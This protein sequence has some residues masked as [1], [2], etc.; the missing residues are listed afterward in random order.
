[1]ETLVGHSLT[2][3]IAS[4]RAQKEK[5]EAERLKREADK[6]A[7]EEEEAAAAL[8]KAEADRKRAAEQ[9]AR[10]ERKREA[11][12]AEAARKAAEKQKRA[13]KQLAEE[14][15]RRAEAE[16]QREKVAQDKA[17]AAAKKEAARVQREA[18][19]KEKR[20]KDKREKE[21]KEKAAAERKAAEEHARKERER[22]QAEARAA[23][24]A[25]QAAQAAARAQ[26]QQSPLQP[27]SILQP[28]PSS[29]NRPMG[30]P[31]SPVRG[32]SA[33][34]N[35]NRAMPPTPVGLPPTSSPAGLSRGAPTVPLGVPHTP[36]KQPMPSPGPVGPFRG[37][38]Q[39]HQPP[40][41]GFAPMSPFGARPPS[42]QGMM[43]MSMTPSATSESPTHSRPASTIAGMSASPM[44]FPQQ[45]FGP[46]GLGTH[47]Q[48]MG[49]PPLSQA[50]S[51]PSGSTSIFSS[52]PTA[53][54]MNGA[55]APPGFRRPSNAHVAPIGSSSYGNIGVTAGQPMQRN[56]SGE[57]ARQPSAIGARPIGRPPPRHGTGQTSDEV[58][59]AALRSPTPPLTF[60]SA[61]LLDDD[62]EDALADSE[63][64]GGGNGSNSSPTASS[65]ALGGSYTDSSIWGGSGLWPAAARPQPPPLAVPEPQAP[66][67]TR[68][69]ILRARL[70][71]I[72]Y[73]LTKDHV[74]QSA[75]SL[76]Y[77]DWDMVASLLVQR[78]PDSNT[79]TTEELIKC[80]ELPADHIN[81]GGSFSLKADP[82]RVLIAFQ[83]QD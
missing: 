30:M 21:K 22:Q 76:I 51:L 71:V 13:E 2:A 20:E 4:Y 47:P 72:C 11:K 31:P 83:P 33:G 59:P 24:Q 36:G 34:N 52:A 54:A 23:A 7:A 9:A 73:E 48:P 70:A 75:T 15:R 68:A 46:I 63:H 42:S 28:S 19:E 74:G 18:A 56:T 67:N 65:S 14:E 35:N 79:A 16:K 32:Y 38:P 50:Q 55:G 82:P 81:G 29:G 66:V 1:M 43:P 80:C 5:A 62:D 39:Q 49:R 60:G 69:S 17:A 53:T 77:H 10:E 8:A 41:P 45:S 37:Q 25:K 3:L 61:A 64:G 6:K 27:T 40:P 12:A 26:V 44:P 58:D 78:F 57:S